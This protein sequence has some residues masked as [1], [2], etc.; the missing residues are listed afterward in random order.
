[1]PRTL[2]VLLLLIL[3]CVIALAVAAFCSLAVDY[4]AL[5]PVLVTD[6]EVDAFHR[7]WT[8]DRPA[9]FPEVSEFSQ[10]DATAGVGITIVGI[11]TKD[12]SNVFRLMRVRSG[13]P[14]KCFEGDDW[15]HM[16]LAPDTNLPNRQMIVAGQST[17]K[18]LARVLPDLIPLVTMSSGKYIPYGVVWGGLAINTLVYAIA[19]LALYAGFVW[20]R[21]RRRV[22]AG[23]CRECGYQLKELT[24]CPECGKSAE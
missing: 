22:G 21:N 7:D 23:C 5:V 2:L 18:N 24:R 10:I 15:R 1:M 13:W 8:A 11:G 14:M 4:S 6:A 19:L 17:Y 12:Q 20:L 16:T 3:G 9:G